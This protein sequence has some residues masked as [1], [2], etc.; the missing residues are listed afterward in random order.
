V[1]KEVEGV[2]V[3]VKVKGCNKV[4]RSIFQQQDVVR[5]ESI[6]QNCNKKRMIWR[7]ARERGKRSG[8]VFSILPKMDFRPF[9]GAPKTDLGVRLA[10]LFVFW[11]PPPFQ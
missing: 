3:E 11:Y 5:R 8:K 10:V 2:E 9:Q 4:F 6:Q 7:R 1:E